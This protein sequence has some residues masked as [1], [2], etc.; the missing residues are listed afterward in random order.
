[1]SVT[2][3]SGAHLATRDDD[4]RVAV[5]VVGKTLRQ[6]ISGLAVDELAAAL[7]SN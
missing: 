3:V 7:P 1:M 4:A 2:F 5:G 6:T